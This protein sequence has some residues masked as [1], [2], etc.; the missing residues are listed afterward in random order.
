M[1]SV[2]GSAGG[3]ARPARQ[4]RVVAAVLAGAAALAVGV[5]SF[6]VLFTGSI[7]AG[8]ERLTMVITSWGFDVEGGSRSGAVPTG[9]YVLIFAAA[10]LVATTV[11]CALAAASPQSPLPRT[12]A[13][14]AVATVAFLAAA[15]WMTGLQ[16]VSFADSLHENA[17]GVPGGPSVTVLTDTGPGFWLLA[18]AVVLAGLSA[19]LVLR[20]TRDLSAAQLQADL[21]T[22]RHGFLMPSPYGPR[23]SM[24][25]RWAPAQPPFTANRTETPTPAAQPASPIPTAP[26]VPP[27]EPTPPESSGQPTPP[28]SPGP[29]A[30]G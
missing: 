8:G 23:P 29:S 18:A 7:A 24:P 11:L 30:S 26:P 14:V 12:A 13:L 9:G 17:A 28:A 2:R 20:S 25:G 16:V 1:H 19:L 15:V 3:Y 5:G 6:G 22:P 4:R 10:L 21:A 27:V